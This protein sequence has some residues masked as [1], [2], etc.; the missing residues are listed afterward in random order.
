MRALCRALIGLFLAALLLPLAGCMGASHAAGPGGVGAGMPGDGGVIAGVV[1]D[2]L[3]VPI[4]GATVTLDGHESMLTDTN[5]SFRFGLVAPGERSLAATLEGYASA[6]LMVTVIV[7]EASQASLTLVRDSIAQAYH[8]TATQS[9]FIACS[10]GLRDP[11][12]A[13]DTYVNGC[14]VLIIAGLGS[15]DKIGLD[16]KIGQRSGDAV[17]FWG[18]TRWVPSF[19]ASPGLIVRW[20]VQN[21]PLY[22]SNAADY[23]NFEAIDLAGVK[24]KTPLSVRIPMDWLAKESLVNVGR[25][26]CPLEKNCYLGSGH[27]PYSQTTSS[28]V[29]ATAQVQQR[30]E[31]FLTIFHKG[32]LPERF[33]ALPDQ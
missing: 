21:A 16:W 28:T 15:L 30:Y 10:T 4:V 26:V 2:D 1:V 20:A 23:P 12:H 19:S 32:V 6:T 33:T 31:E 13:N 8:E 5:G 7:G 18:E 25:P 3:I 22:S 27:I 29:D 11:A 14:G 24:G 9:G 17:G